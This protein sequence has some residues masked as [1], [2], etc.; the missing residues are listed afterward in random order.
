MLIPWNDIDSLAFQRID[1]LKSVPK[2]RITAK[3]IE[4]SIKGYYNFGRFEAGPYLLIYNH[5]PVEGNRFRLGG[6]TNI[7]FSRK[8]IL[9]GY[10]AYGTRDDRFKGSVQAEYFLFE[11]TLVQNRNP[12]QG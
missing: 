12:I 4:A 8:W 5:N 7:N 6:R 1:S 11:E 9:E 2:V 3:L 10:L